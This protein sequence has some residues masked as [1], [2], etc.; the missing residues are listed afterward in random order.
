MKHVFACVDGSA[1]TTAV[2]DYASWAAQRLATPLTLFHVLDE[3]RYPLH[4]EL[5]GNIGLGDQQQLLEQLAE[6]DSQRNQLALEHGRNM[7][8]AGHRRANENGV[9]EVFT[10]Q[11]H[12]QLPRALADVEASIRL[13]VVGL[14]G[15]DSNDSARCGRQ[16]E[17]LVRQ[18]QKPTLV[19]PKTFRAPGTV[20]LAFDG[21]DASRKGVKL[22][23]ESPIFK[24]MPIT[25][26]SVGER[27]HEAE[28]AL[29]AAA[30]HLREHRHQVD[31]DIVQGDVATALLDYQQQHRIDLVVMGAFSH[32]RARQW[33]LGST[34]RKLLQSA[35]VPL[36][37]LR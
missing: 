1:S 17:P 6:L 11:H 30:N 4:S 24:G 37:L 22:L 16:L 29:E 27:T 33:F 19:T 8:E 26:V 23:A 14:H 25:L 5:T 10:R 31:S 34:T 9:N 2:C 12:G 36:L 32:S 3:L 7:L 15:V 28:A 20:M 21:S 35:E 18:L 13:L